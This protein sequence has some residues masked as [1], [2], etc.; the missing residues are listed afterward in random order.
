MAADYYLVLGVACD[1]TQDQIKS[2]YRNKV[3]EL[4]PDHY[5]GGSGPFR[6]V[7]EA[8]EVLG[9]PARRR[10][11]DEA[12]SQ[13]YRTRQPARWADPQ[14]VRRRHPSAEPLVPT[15][16][17]TGTWDPFYGASYPSLFEELL[18]RAWGDP[19]PWRAPHARTQSDDIH[20]Q[21]SLTRQQAMRGGRLR[22]AVPTQVRC[23]ACHGRG[24]AGFFVCPHCYG[25]GAVIDEY[26]VEAAYP[27]GVADGATGR[28]ALDLPDGRDV[29][30]TFHFSVDPW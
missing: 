4:H 15:R 9:D 26:P 29:I 30:L 27:A 3:K 1:A 10:S 11:Y 5:A 2:A 25:R 20:L 14:S 23:P 18:G 6:A 17:R 28:L 22:I 7:Q 12:L 13:E 16:G 19:A 24:T 8:Y 21:V